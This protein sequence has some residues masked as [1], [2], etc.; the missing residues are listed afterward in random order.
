MG[1]FSEVQ[2]VQSE[3]TN[4]LQEQIDMNQMIN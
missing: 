1:N 4:I 3:Q 2:S